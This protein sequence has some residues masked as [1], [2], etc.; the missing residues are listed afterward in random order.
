M[1]SILTLQLRVVLRMARWAVKQQYPVVLEHFG[2][3]SCLLA[4]RPIQTQ[5]QR[6]AIQPDV[7]INCRRD[8]GRVV[9][10]YGFEQR[11]VRDAG[12]RAPTSR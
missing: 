9:L 5:H 10:R 4:A 11:P 2:H 6:C 12:V 8:R 1:L 7:R 3:F